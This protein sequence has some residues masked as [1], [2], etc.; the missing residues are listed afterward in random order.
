MLFH[1]IE[2]LNHTKPVDFSGVFT[3]LEEIDNDIFDTQTILCDKFEQTW[4][5]LANLK[6]CDV[7][8]EIS[9]PTTITDPGCYCLINDLEG[10]ISIGSSHVT[11]NLNGFEIAG[12][13]RN[14]DFLSSTSHSDIVIK[15]GIL[16]NAEKDAIEIRNVTNVT[17]QDVEFIDNAIG[18]NV[19]TS[20]C[21]QVENCTFRGHSDSV[22]QVADS[23]T[24]LVQNVKAFENIA[25][26]NINVMNFKNSE[27]VCVQNAL[28]SRNS[29]PEGNLSGINFSNCAACQV[30]QTKVESNDSSDT[31]IGYNG[32]SSSSLIF[33]ESSAIDNTAT[34]TAIGFQFDTTETSC[35]LNCVAKHNNATGQEGSEV[36]RGFFLN[37][38]NGCHVQD[39]LAVANS[40]FSSGIGFEVTQTSAL[41]TAVLGNKSQQH[42]DNFIPQADLSVVVFTIAGPPPFYSATPA[43]F[44]NLSIV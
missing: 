16:R 17:I 32:V 31:T 12:A 26:L 36:G 13:V 34:N 15:N 5:I 37:E 41:T 28:I 29:S 27:N 35:I 22:I 4:T 33:N 20:T 9:E 42:Q 39:N 1:K 38:C 7:C 30:M 25:L 6:G 14:I 44:D 40:G 18:V 3:V 8:T 23:D 11:L 19:F 24:I 10:P 2:N 21:I 43:V